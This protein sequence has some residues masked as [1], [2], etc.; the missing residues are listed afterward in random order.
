MGGT[1]IECAVLESAENPKVLAR[2]RIPT[3]GDKGYEHIIA[4]IKKLVGIVSDQLGFSPTSLGI[5]TP[6][7]VDPLT[8]L[9]KNSNTTCLNGM[10]FKE[11]LGKALGIPVELANDANCF[12]L[13]E[14]RMG[15]VPEVLPDAKV[16]FGVILGTGV[17]GGVVVNGE[18]LN[19]RQ[20]IGGEWGT[21]FS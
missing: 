9:H 4:Q 16:S 14:A 12:A 17:G 21:Q 19:G 5:G 18:V 10:P 2:E 11:D 7:T 15:A 13:A 1:K 20:G 3:E 8:G 6:G